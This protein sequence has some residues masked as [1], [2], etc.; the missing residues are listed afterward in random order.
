M[1]KRGDKMQLKENE[2]WCP[3]CKKVVEMTFR[4]L[5]RNDGLVYFKDTCQ[6]CFNPIIKIIENKRGKE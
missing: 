1:K 2:I 4:I 5:K 6:E 3:H